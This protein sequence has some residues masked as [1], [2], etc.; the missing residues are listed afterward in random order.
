MIVRN[1]L[2][3]IALATTCLAPLA[4]AAQEAA[5][6]IDSTPFTGFVGLG[7]IGVA[8][9]N[10]DQAGRYDGLNTTGLDIALGEFDLSGRAPW[11]SGRTRYYDFSGDNLIFQTGNHFG[12]GIG[13]D[14]SNASSTTNSLA[15]E[16]ALGFKVGDQGTWGFGVDYEAI[17]YTGNVIDSLYTVNGGQALLNNNLA[18]FGGATATAKGPVTA[19]T[20]PTL[21]AT[22]AMQPVQTFTRRDIIGTDFKYIWNDWTVV[23]ALRHEHKEGSME[24]SFFG[25]Y[26]GTAFAMP[27][28]YDTDRYDLSASYTTRAFQSIFQYTFS[29]FTDNNLFVSLPYP[30]SN[31]A[32]PFQRASAYSLPP[33]N[34]AHYLTMMLADS[35]LI[36]KTRLNLNARVGLE[37]QN[38]TFA[39]NTADPSGAN[40]IGA[41]GLS[42][43]NRATLDGTTAASPNMMAEIYQLKISAASHPMTN[44]DT[45]VFYGLDGRSV[46]LNQYQVNV[47][48]EGGGTS[49]TTL[50]GVAFVVPQD[51]L[52]QNAGAEAGYR[53]IPE[54]DTK[55]TVGYRLDTV[56]RSNAQVGHSTTNTASTALSS[57]FGDQI[58]GRLTF[59]YADRTGTLSY[60]TPWLNLDGPTA[61]PTYSGAFYQAPMTSEAVTLRGDYTPIQTVS[62]SFFLQFKNENY[63]YPAANSASGVSTANAATIPIT[64]VGDGVKQDYTLTLGPDV[65]YRPRENLDIHIFYTYE[66]LFY[67]NMGNGACST[68][69]QAAT[70]ACKGTAGYFQNN[71]T[72]TTH[73]FGLSSDWK[74][75]E[76]LRLRGEY[77]LSYGTVMFGEFNGV[78]VPNP[79]ASYQNVSNYP[80][81]NSLLNSIKLTSTYQLESN[82]ELI[83]Q[84]IYSSF[85]N[86]DWDNTANAIQGAGTTAISLLTPGYGTPNY[87]IVAIMAGVKFRF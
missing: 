5:P 31:T 83:L 34:D 67:N 57:R 47:G 18:P 69:A 78:F 10:P 46:S 59:A 79:T 50:N 37:V 73:T 58:D 29:H 15:N 66:L 70:A 63:T 16:G 12:G 60:L 9:H 64:D 19:F 14:N 30:T 11:D 51:W 74:V 85:H 4:A 71:D 55:V 38:D 35:D 20:I 44:V 82:V 77:T 72:S 84:G 76:K 80:D 48:G 7:L 26:G 68:R 43:L 36:P 42:S 2:R 45:R 24:E 13:S 3:A 65:N 49:D 32:A 22:G 6:T 75:T 40:L 8:G 81:I 23:G 86:N 27:I 33:S 41:P 1:S 54:Y 52:K 56:E 25:P 61:T 28:D 62:S 39:P 21:T 17:T 53:F 87:N